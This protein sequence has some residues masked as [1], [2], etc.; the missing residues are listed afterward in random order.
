MDN[1][2]SVPLEGGRFV[3][4]SL[5]FIISIYHPDG[6]NQHWVLNRF[7]QHKRKTS[8]TNLLALSR[9]WQSRNRVALLILVITDK[10]IELKFQE[11]TI[12]CNQDT[13]HRS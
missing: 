2:S 1:E 4:D 7:K 13:F 12:L 10:V 9:L 3:L 8:A 11:V 5:K 6:K